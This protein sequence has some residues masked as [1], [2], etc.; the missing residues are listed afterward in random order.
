MIWKFEDEETSPPGRGELSTL[1]TLVSWGACPTE[2][3]RR[4]L[5]S[6]EQNDEE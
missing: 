5:L 4:G 6:S 2:S 1:S 3:F